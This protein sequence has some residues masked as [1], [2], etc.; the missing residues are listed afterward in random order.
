[1]FITDTQ[2]EDSNS[3]K[4]KSVKKSEKQVFLEH[5][6]MASQ[7]SPIFNAIL[8]GSPIS[9]EQSSVGEGVSEPRFLQ[10]SLEYLQDF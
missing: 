2:D 6:A 9:K 3:E 4:K 8:S 1:M 10:H 7:A 5:M